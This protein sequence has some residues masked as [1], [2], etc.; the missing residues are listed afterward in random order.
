MVNTELLEDK[1]KE[2]GKKKSFLAKRCNL[3][4]QGFALKCTN[5]QDFTA[6]QIMVLCDELNIQSLTLKDKIF[7]LES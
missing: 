3:S 7:L 6:T 2:S 5:K 4:R 1:I